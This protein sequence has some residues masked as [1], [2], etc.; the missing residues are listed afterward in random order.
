MVRGAAMRPSTS[1]FIKLQALSVV[2]A[3]AAGACAGITGDPTAESGANV[4][5]LPTDGLAVLEV[6]VPA[7]VLTAPALGGFPTLGGGGGGAS[8]WMFEYAT[9]QDRATVEPGKALRV[10]PGGCLTVAYLSN[11]VS[12]GYPAVA[13]KHCDLGLVA[14]QKTTVPFGAARVAFDVEKI[15]VDFGRRPLPQLVDAS[16]SVQYDLGGRYEGSALRLGAT[17]AQAWPFNI[18]TAAQTEVVAVPLRA[19]QYKLGYKVDGVDAAIV[20]V[21]A[22]VVRTV[23]ATPRD[24]RSTLRLTADDAAPLP[25]AGTQVLTF[26]VVGLEPAVGRG[27]MRVG[28]DG[29]TAKF[30]PTGPS[31]Q[32]AFDFSDAEQTVPAP[33]TVTVPASSVADAVLPRIDVHD[34]AVTADG[35]PTA[36]KGTW[37]LSRWNGAEY[38]L[39]ELCQSTS[40][41]NRCTSSRSAYDLKTQTGLFVPAGSYRVSVTWRTEA[42]AQEQKRDFD[43][44]VP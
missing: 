30:F 2:T 4:D 34:V 7:G 10:R 39:T 35:A 3:L 12:G 25:Q 24:V 5:V 16:G 32:V 44:T 31:D 37:Q 23:D 27:H 6:T 38:K 17:P 26:D 21:E 40:A 1:S 9:A 18:R 28:A 13:H 15:R 14:G 8:G 11:Y 43:V 41:D 36:V 29:L 33:R 19:G 20:D 22:G 42:D